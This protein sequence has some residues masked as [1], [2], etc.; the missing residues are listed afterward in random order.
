[1]DV[2]PRLQL[3]IIKPTTYAPLLKRVVQPV[4]ESPVKVAVAN[5]TRVEA[6]VFTGTQQ[7][8]SS[9]I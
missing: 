6:R 7:T 3:M 5:E 4:C 2:M 9:L 1:M 8:R